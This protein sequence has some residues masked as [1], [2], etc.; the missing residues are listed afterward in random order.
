MKMEKIGLGCCLLNP[1][2]PG[3]CSGGFCS[4]VGVSVQSGDPSPC[5]QTDASEYLSLRSVKML[6]YVFTRRTKKSLD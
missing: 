3:I 6:W 1:K 2:D 4:R 5:G